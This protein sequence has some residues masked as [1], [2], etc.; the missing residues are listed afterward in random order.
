MENQTNQVSVLQEAFLPY[1]K[2]YVQFLKDGLNFSGSMPM[3]AYFRAT[4]LHYAL[5]RYL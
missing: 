2:N 3:N 4:R 1:W 5:N